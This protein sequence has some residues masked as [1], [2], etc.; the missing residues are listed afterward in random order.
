MIAKKNSG[1]DLERKRTVLFQIGLLTA[2]SFTLAAFSYS[3]STKIELEKNAVAFEPVTYFEQVPEV[4]KIEI[5]IIKPPSTNEPSIDL[6]NQQVSQNVSSTQN[7]TT[8]PRPDISL[9]GGFVA[10]TGG[11][12]EIDGGEFDP[13]PP[14]EAEYYGG[15]VQMQLD[16]SETIVYPEIDQRIG[17][18]GTVYVSFIVEKNGAVS[19]VQIERGISETIDREAKRI[20]KGF[21]NWKPAENAFGKVRTIVRLPIRFILE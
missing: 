21:P 12:V 8:I 3:T 17:N 5:P 10:V 18:Q 11:D 15:P 13:F 19:N 16:I 14:I 6:N 7:S 2:G 1:V 4:K 9:P 20:V